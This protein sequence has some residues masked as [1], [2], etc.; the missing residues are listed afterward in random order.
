MLPLM[1]SNRCTMHAK[2]E[3]VIPQDGQLIRNLFRMWDPKCYLAQ[4]LRRYTERSRF[5]SS[6]HRP[7]PPSP[8]GGFNPHKQKG[9]IR[10]KQTACKSTRGT[11]PNFSKQLTE[12]ALRCL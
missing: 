7:P 6:I 12:R 5:W 4:E 8:S 1:V 2:R 3:T 10:T 9:R 11:G